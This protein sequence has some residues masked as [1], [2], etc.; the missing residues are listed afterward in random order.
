MQIISIKTK[1]ARAGDD[2]R[3]IITASLENI[4]ERSVLVVTSKLFSTCE[5]C[6]VEKKIGTREEK[7][8]L[9]KREAELYTDPKDSKYNMMLTI[10]KN[11]LFA[12]AGIDE[13]N[14]D[15]RYIVWP[16]DPQKSVNDLWKF[17]R[18]HYSVRELGITMSDSSSC[19][20][21]RGAIGRA[22]AHCGFKAL[23][24]YIGEPD[25]FGRLL[26]AEQ[27]N[28]AQS[29]TDGAVLEMGEGNECRPIALVTDFKNKIE[30]CNQVPTKE[31]LTELNISLEDDIYASILTQNKW[32]KG[33]SGK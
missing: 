6:F 20:L 9:I 29:L 14:A 15:G 16:K 24:S 12:S 5:N 13:S 8:E 30:F 4:P 3:K 25:L 33:K 7:Q 32:K 10:K 26:K 1:L 19:I 21:N 22:I 17:L 31:E 28:V 23:R 11:M 27:A 18:E 2:I